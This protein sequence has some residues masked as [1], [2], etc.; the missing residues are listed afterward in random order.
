MLTHA[1]ATEHPDQTKKES[2]IAERPQSLPKEPGLADQLRPYFAE[3]LGTFALTFV[4]AGGEVIAHVSGGE[5]SHAARMIA[6][7]LVVMALIYAIGDA[8]GAHF[9][10]AV[11]FAF[12]ARCSFPWTRVPGYWASHMI[13]SLLAAALLRSLFGNVADLGA[14]HPHYGVG[15]SFVMEVFLTMLLITVILGTAT[16]YS[17]IGPNAALAVGAT[18]ALCGLFA[19]P[20]S[21]ASMNPARSLGPALLSGKVDSA[22]VYLAGPFLGSALATLGMAY[23]HKQKDPKEDE[24]AEGDEGKEQ[25]KKKGGSQ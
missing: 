9:N 16:R 25:D 13:G 1:V 24:A 17:L 20:I 21:G 12:A 23:L 2:H 18:I 15:T 19:G 8:S 4:A 3:M 6:P 7:G 22:W 10:P 14:N 5:V 11:T